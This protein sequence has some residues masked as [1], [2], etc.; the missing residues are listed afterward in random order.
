M[1]ARNAPIALGQPGGVPMTPTERQ[2]HAALDR[3][4]AQFGTFYFD[5]RRHRMSLPLL[6]RWLLADERPGE[7][8]NLLLRYWRTG[9]DGVADRLLEASIRLALQGPG[10]ALPALRRAATI[11]PTDPAVQRRLLQGLLDAGEE[12][13]AARVAQRLLRSARDP[14]VLALALPV[15][16]PDWQAFGVAD[17]DGPHVEGWCV[18]RGEATTRTCSVLADGRQAEITVAAEPN[19]AWSR[20]GVHFGRIRLAW[21]AGATV[22]SLRDAQTQ[23]EWRGSPLMDDEVLDDRRVFGASDVEVTVIVPV[24]ADAAATRRCFESL[25][26]DTLTTTRRRI[27][28]VDDASPDGMIRVLLDR[29]AASGQIV[30]LRNPQNVG[31]IRAVNRALKLVGQEDVVLLNADTMVPPGWLDRL[32]AA[33]LTP[34]V[35]TVTP[36]SNN[37]E[38]VSCP[39]GFRANPMPDREMLLGL[40]HAAQRRG[41]API[42]MPNG[43]GF[44]LY[45]RNDA[46]RAVGGLD[47][48]HYERGYL[49]EVDFCL[50]I[51]AAG[52]RNVCTTDL[53]VAHQGEAS[54]GASKREL[55]MANASAL[56]RRWPHIEAETEAFVK[57]DP[58]MPVRD[59]LAWSSLKRGL[60]R[61]LLVVGARAPDGAVV[62]RLARESTAELA[63]LCAAGLDPARW[64]VCLP[65]LDRAVPLPEDWGRAQPAEALGALCDLLGA[66]DVVLGLARDL[67]EGVA[68]LAADLGLPLDVMPLEAGQRCPPALSDKVRRHVLLAPSAAALAPEGAVVT[69]LAAP[70]GPP[71]A[72]RSLRGEAM[73][74][75]PGDA[76]P[77]T[78]ALIRDIARA[79]HRRRSSRPLIVFG[80]TARDVGLL[81]LGN[82]FVTGALETE[83]DWRE[84]F[85]AHPCGGLL[86]ALRRPVFAHRAFDV[87]RRAGLPFAAFPVGGAAD[88]LAALPD[89]LA[90]DPAW[91]AEQLALVADTLMTATAVAGFHRSFTDVA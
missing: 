15:A 81:R 87:V 36:L 24:Y 84:A 30:L 79:L 45:V 72:P 7:A 33:A 70:A 59:A 69:S 82:V 83:E 54:F 11:D 19:P 57:A 43:V 44:C 27:V 58:L 68:G 74:I 76:S 77:A 42:D 64:R 41:G 66:T 80:E 62:E 86:L 8:L 71:L 63:V 22:V 3:L 90:L 6:A 51:A 91:T 61:R 20:I 88:L 4:V 47:A 37:G 16:E 14:D 10:A 2:P 21:P 46:L 67:P 32:R 12:R 52:Y 75:L 5:E 31:F 40:D 25:A 78:F 23:S 35:G 9:A 53:F 29:L 17:R 49:E 60:A 89:G 73:G 56:M 65:G 34:D 39:N 18:W 26:V 28:A 50:R 55:V 1:A 38:F 85:A 13:E 48:R